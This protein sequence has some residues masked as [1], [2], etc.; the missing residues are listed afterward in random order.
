[1]PLSSPPKEDGTGSSDAVY[2][3]PAGHADLTVGKCPG[4]SK[5]STPS[6]IVGTAEQY[7]FCYPDFHFNPFETVCKIT[8]KISTLKF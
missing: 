6:C 2:I 8:N 4:W 7:F 1:M 3:M 5:L